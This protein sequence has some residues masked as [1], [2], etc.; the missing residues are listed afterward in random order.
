M[1][2]IVG[3]HVRINFILQMAQYIFIT[4]TCHHMVVH[5]EKKIFNMNIFSN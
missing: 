2:F 4:D 3:L 1:N 5:K